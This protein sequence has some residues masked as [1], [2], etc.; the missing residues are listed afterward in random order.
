M[1]AAF[2]TLAAISALLAFASAAL[3]WTGLRRI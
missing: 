1:S 2:S 3:A